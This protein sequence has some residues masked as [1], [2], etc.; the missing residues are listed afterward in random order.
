MVP[1]AVT[2]GGEANGRFA[3]VALG[4]RRDLDARPSF[5]LRRSRWV[6]GPLVDVKPPSAAPEPIEVGKTTAHTFG[7]PVLPTHLQYPKR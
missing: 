3:A 7:D 1:P 2:H 4:D 5:A 6:R